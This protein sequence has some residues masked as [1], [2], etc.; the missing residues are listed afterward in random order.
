MA[1]RD[2]KIEFIVDLQDKVSKKLAGVQGKF[3]SFVKV[4]VKAAAALAAGLAV[5]TAAFVKLVNN[6]TESFDVFAKLSDFTGASTETLSALAFAAERSGVAFTSLQV[7]IRGMTRNIATAA[8]GTGEAA[9]ALRELNLNV[10][11]LAKLE[12]DEQMIVIGDAISKVESGTKRL[13]LAQYIFGGRAAEVI[14]I[15]KDGRKGVVEYFDKIR[16]LNG[17]ITGPAAEASARYQDSL[18]NL[19]TAFQGVKVA[20]VDSGIIDAMTDFINLFAQIIALGTGGG[21]L[22]E[23]FARTTMDVA[24]LEKQLKRLEEAGKPDPGGLI[25]DLENRLAKAKERMDELLLEVGE[26]NLESARLYGIKVGEAIGGGLDDSVLKSLQ[27]FVDSFDTVTMQVDKKLE[28]LRQAIAAGLIPNEAE[29]ERIRAAILEALQI[30]EVIVPK[31]KKK[32]GSTAPAFDFLKEAA[33]GAAMSMQSSFADFFMDF[34]GGLKGMLKL[35]LQVMQR[36]LAE[37][38][39]FKTIK[40][41]GF[42][43][44][45]SKILG[46]ASGGG[47]PGGS[48]MMV[49]E[50]GPELVSF[51]PQGG[52]VT[53]NAAL[54]TT[55]NGSQEMQ[56]V[57]NIDARGADPSLISRLPGVLDQ[58]DKRLMLAVQRYIRTGM[59]S[60]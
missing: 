53:S 49:G 28:T 59:L 50:R 33:K 40:G 4:V 37:V 52:H 13:T 32:I 39:A 3:Q 16:D 45:F 26:R 27:G 60:I 55:N 17:L 48:T 8:E 42:E 41:L 18:T 57:T 47:V 2:R 43:D 21:D 9:D 23:R 5:A 38:L 46:R 44:I 10:Q 24:N 14:K 51:G 12:F 34:E 56:F 22:S 35:F 31:I 19:K 20:L 11:D 54:R 6:I 25:P 58:R 30:E 7:G 36:M 15:F 1:L 29:Q